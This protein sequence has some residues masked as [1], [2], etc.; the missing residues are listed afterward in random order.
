MRLN[1][2]QTF[3][4]SEAQ[5]AASVP[6]RPYIDDLISYLP[7]IRNTFAHPTDQWIFAPGMA[8][9]NLILATEVI[10]QLWDAPEQS[11]QVA[12]PG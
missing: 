10:N 2:A 1:V 6:S 5:V 12:T 3:G 11:T 8:L 4:D 9:D 7:R